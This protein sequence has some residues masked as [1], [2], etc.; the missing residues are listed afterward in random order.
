MNQGNPYK[1]EDGK[2]GSPDN[3]A[4]L[5]YE[6]NKDEQIKKNEKQAAVLNKNAQK[7]AEL[8]H[9]NLKQNDPINEEILISQ[10]QGLR[11]ISDELPQVEKLLQKYY[12]HGLEVVVEK[13]DKSDKI[14]ENVVI[15]FLK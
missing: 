1:R 9:I 10:I 5:L 4:Y 14:G 6:P 15:F 2:F 13:F 12:G 11:D 3:Y 8:Y 7:L